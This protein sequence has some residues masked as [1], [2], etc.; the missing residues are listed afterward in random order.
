MLKIIEENKKEFSNESLIKKAN[1]F[2]FYTNTSLEAYTLLQGIERVFSGDIRNHALKEID[3][4][5]IV[6]LNRMDDKTI[7]G[8]SSHFLNNQLE[9]LLQTNKTN[10]IELL[11]D[12]AEREKK[13]KETLDLNL[14]TKI[15][16]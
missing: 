4:F 1:T 9:A 5:D 14:K 7:N 13:I 10:Y 15:F 12:Y 8:I 3:S 11:D 16:L 2:A 6:F